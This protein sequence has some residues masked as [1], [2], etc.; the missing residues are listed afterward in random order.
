VLLAVAHS[1]DGVRGEIPSPPLRL[2]QHH[3]ELDAEHRERHAGYQLDDDAVDPKV[4]VLEDGVY[5]RGL[6][7]LDKVERRVGRA[8]ED[9]GAAGA[10]GRAV[11]MLGEVHAHSPLVEHFDLRPDLGGD[12]ERD[13]EY[14]AGHVGER[15][16]EVS[17]LVVAPLAIPLRMRHRDVSPDCQGHRQVDG[18]GVAHLAKVGV[19][20]HKDTPAVRVHVP[21]R[22]VVQVHV[23]RVRNVLDHHE[24]IGHGETREDYVGGR[25]HLVPRQ[26]GD[27]QDIGDRAEYA[28][29]QAGPAVDQAIV[30]DHLPRV[31]A[32]VLG[33]HRFELGLG[34]GLGQVQAGQVEA[35]IHP[36][37]IPPGGGSSSNP[38]RIRASR[39]LPFF[40]ALRNS[41][42][43]QLQ[44]SLPC[45]RSS[46][47]SRFNSQDA[48][49][50]CNGLIYI[51]IAAARN[52]IDD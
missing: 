6:G 25:A 12:I 22:S 38:P 37:R 48:S 16:H 34:L 21:A 44:D 27:V 7:E 35:G 8:V 20:Q 19:E 32:A 23:D 49:F 10:I 43:L 42:F 51:L 5:P 11:P 3:D 1:D 17:A 45:S 31:R 14:R 15:D 39:G 28:H 4:D 41:A 52:W 36:R 18:D 29:Q 26:H 50:C 46:S 40:H 33:V 24:E 30:E 13:A 47:L 2:H 9:R